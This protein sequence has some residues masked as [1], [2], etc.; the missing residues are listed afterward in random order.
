MMTD[1]VDHQIAETTM[2]EWRKSTSRTPTLCC[3]DKLDNGAASYWHRPHH[4]EER[5]CACPGDVGARF[6]VYINMFM[7]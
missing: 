3:D 4:P 6:N 2:S 5:V 1:N 7:Q